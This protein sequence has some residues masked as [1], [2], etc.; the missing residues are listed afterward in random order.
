MEHA[1]KMILVP[2][3]TVERLGQVPKSRDPLEEMHKELTHILEARDLSDSEKWIKYQQV[4]ERGLRYGE[5]RRKPLSFSLDMNEMEPKIN[6]IKEPNQRIDEE[7]DLNGVGEQNHEEAAPVPR[8]V[9]REQRIYQEP[10]LRSPLHYS[11][12]D[13]LST[14]PKT[15]REKG[16]VLLRKL[17]KTELIKWGED[18]SV[19]IG[20]RPIAGAN[21]TDL[22][23]DALRKRKTIS[24]PVGFRDFYAALGKL[25]LPQELIGNPDRLHLIRNSAT[26]RERADSPYF[27]LLKPKVASSLK[28]HKR[29]SVETSKPPRRAIDWETFSFK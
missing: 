2:A 17:G 21:I 6:Q 25:N 1:K 9:R 13:I 23:N 19:V 22:I 18:G 5:Q 10:P 11:Y 14:V 28:P 20:N 4:L 7:E 26:V 15:L 8:V 29:K 16:S 24:D 12:G 3:E 27:S